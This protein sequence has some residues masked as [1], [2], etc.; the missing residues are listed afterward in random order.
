MNLRTAAELLRSG[1]MRVLL[2]AMRLVTPYYRLLWLVAAFR[3][4]LIARL[5]G[6]ARSFEELARDRVQ[7]A[8]DR[9]WLRAWLELGVR[10]GQLRL[11]GERYSLRSYLARQLARPANDAIAAILEEVATLH[12]RLVL[13]SPTRM[14]AGRRFTLADQDGV[15]VARSSP[16]LRP[17][18]HEAIDKVVPRSG[19]FRMLE[20]GA[21]SGTY[22]RYAAERNPELS[23]VGLELQPEVADFANANLREWGLERR[24]HVEP[25]DVRD[26]KPEPEFDL[27]TFHNNIYYFPVAERVALLRHARG[28]LRPGAAIV[29]TTACGGGSP[30][31]IGLDIW[32]AGTER[33]GRL[34][35]P[36][37]L[38]VQMREAGF[39]DARASSLFPGEKYYAFFARRPASGG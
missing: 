6:G 14:A 5:E 17:F 29:F 25:G 20:V 21:G 22:I 28:F 15:L 19:A 10:V 13:E 12:Y 35:E 31:S 1:Q 18:V 37:E 24:A 9:D 11:E 33:C 32:S 16:L 7:D 39:D 36:E 23:A 3:S 26:R 34:P 27:V 38:V 8:A 4:G 30:T 2:G